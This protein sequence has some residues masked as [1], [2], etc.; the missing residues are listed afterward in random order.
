MNFY[1]R[2]QMINFCNSFV[3]CVQKL[4]LTALENSEISISCPIIQFEHLCVPFKHD[5]QSDM[6]EV[7]QLILPVCTISSWWSNRTTIVVI[8]VPRLYRLRFP[9]VFTSKPYLTSTSGL[10]DGVTYKQDMEFLFGTLLL[11]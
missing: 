4:M 1:Y 8:L 11:K 2:S 5:P 10:A 6:G 7:E 3:T 9:F